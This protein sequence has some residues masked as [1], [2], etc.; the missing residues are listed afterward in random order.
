MSAESLSLWAASAELILAADRA[1]DLLIASG[2]TP[3]HVVGDMDSVREETLSGPF[4]IHRTPD[5]DRSDAD[6]LLSLGEDLGLESITLAGI[7]GDLL[8]H[9]LGSLSSVIRSNLDI[10][11]ALRRGIAQVVRPRRR[12]TLGTQ[13]GRRISLLPLTPIL[14][15]HL[16][17]VEWPITLQA[18]SLDSF[19]SVSNKATGESVAVEV[20]SG[21][22]LLI[23]E[24]PAEEMP[25]W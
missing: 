10:R 11:L 20:K 7:E 12:Y 9:V 16:E 17:G 5:Q 24:Y 25:N 8:D 18:M 3:H 4:E 21:L 6:K 14:G 23:V 1:A 19:I 15:A 13:S 22:G 2:H